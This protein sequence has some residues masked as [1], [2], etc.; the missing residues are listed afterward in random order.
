MFSGWRPVAAVVTGL[1]PRV[2]VRGL[3]RYW[4]TVLSSTLT[5]SAFLPSG[6]IARSCGPPFMATVA[7]DLEVRSPVVGLME[8]CE[9][10]PPLPPLEAR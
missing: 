6:A 10:V 1:A 7:G 8:Y 4:E 9:T 2:P 3:M 5:T